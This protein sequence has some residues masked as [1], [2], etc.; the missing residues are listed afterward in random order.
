MDEIREGTGV[1]HCGE[2]VP[3]V[4]YLV[5]QSNVLEASQSHP[6]SPPRID[7][8]V[9]EGEIIATLLTPQQRG[10]EC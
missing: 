2:E 9:I 3:V 8:L 6:H 7:L 5:G 10:Q 4:Q 1:Q